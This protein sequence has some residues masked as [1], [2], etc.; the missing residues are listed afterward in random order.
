M[1]ELDDARLSVEFS[2]E[3][4]GM[5]AE[6][7]LMAWIR[8]SMSMITFGFTLI[9]TFQYLFEPGA[10]GRISPHGPRNLGIMLI[11]IGTLALPLATVQYWRYRR[12]LG[13]AGPRLRAFDLTLGVAI[14]VSLLGV[15][16]IMNVLFRLG[17]L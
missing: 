16:A 17:P 1:E 3:R 12:R 6:R 2:R 14:L 15:F 8:T 10:T 13:T 11:G 7:T 5:S 9:K 4:S